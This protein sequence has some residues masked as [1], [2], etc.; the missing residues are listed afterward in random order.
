MAPLKLTSTTLSLLAV[1]M[2][3]PAAGQAGDEESSLVGDWR[4][5]S[6]C[7]VRESACHDED[8][9]YHVEKLSGKPH[10]ISMRLDKIVQGKPVTM[11]TVEC[12]HAVD[13]DTLTC[14]FP[15]GVFRF[16]VTGNK[17]QGTMTLPDKTVWRKISLARV[18]P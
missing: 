7:Q 1:L 15:R 14:E 10:W 3:L 12:L 13:N 5:E 8:S 4:G 2:F 18:E 9:L 11:G 16:T 6:V 17:M